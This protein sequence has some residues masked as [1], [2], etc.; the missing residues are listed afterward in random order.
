AGRVGG[1]VLAAPS[2]VDRRGGVAGTARGGAGP[3]APPGTV[4]PGRD[5]HRRITRASPQRGGHVGPSPVDRG[6]PGSKHHLIVD[7]NG[8]PLQVSL[9]GGNRH[10]VTE[11]LPLVD[12]L[13]AIRGTVGRTRRKP[14]R[15]YADRGYDYD[16]YRRQLRARGI[17]P[18]APRVQWRLSFHGRMRVM[19][20]P[21]KYP[22]ELCCAPGLMEALIPRKDES[23]GCTEEVPGRAA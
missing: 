7:T 12:S 1:D 20:A 16:V 15:R 8:T 3:D 10:D 5:E 21:R 18:V 6:R 9:T 2:G 14:R 11:L 17:T 19:A 23:H 4:G 13:P 22:D